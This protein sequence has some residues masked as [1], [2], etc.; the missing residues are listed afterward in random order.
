MLGNV[1]VGL[2]LVCLLWGIISSMKI[3]QYLSARGTRI[4]YIFMRVMILKYV[5]SYHDMTARH[6]GK[7]GPWYYSYVTAMLL[8]LVFAIIGLSLR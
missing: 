7:P 4:N 6:D 2:A 8:A 5:A 3:V 1:F